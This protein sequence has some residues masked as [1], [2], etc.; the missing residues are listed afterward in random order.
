MRNTRWLFSNASELEADREPSALKT[1]QPSRIDKPQ[2]MS[3]R[4]AIN[5]YYPPDF[6]PLEAENALRKTSKKL[7]TKQR[8]AIT[9]RLMTPFSIRCSKCSEYIAKSRKFNGKK[10]ALPEKYLDTVKIYRLSIKCPRCNNMISFR[11]DPKTADYVMECGGVRNYTKKS[12]ENVNVE[13]VDETLE[14]LVKERKRLETEKISGKG[15]DKMKVLE[16]RLAKIQSEQED[17][18]ELEIM[19]QMASNKM[20]REQ[21]LRMTKEVTF[22]ERE[23]DQKQDL[24][25]DLDKLAE[26]AFNKRSQ[27]TTRQPKINKRP[28]LATKMVLKKGPKKNPL[29][30]IIKKR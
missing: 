10:E 7:K 27:V 24:D 1:V 3:E 28:S 30:V 21:E 12:S 19:K 20:K 11:T 9:I 6:N 17:D 25:H 14:R 4:K 15:D 16:E 18:E 23:Q 29:G 22:E 26:E 5:K 8:D 2:K 13:S